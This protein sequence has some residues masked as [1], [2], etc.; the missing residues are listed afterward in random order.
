MRACMVR[1]VRKAVLYLEIMSVCCGRRV[2]GD[3]MSLE[4]C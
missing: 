4:R 2:Q 3:G 1:V